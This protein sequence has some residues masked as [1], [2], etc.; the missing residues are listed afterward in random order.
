MQEYLPS[1]LIDRSSFLITYSDS[2]LPGSSC[3]GE[4]TITASSCDNH[5][6]RHFLQIP[7]LMCPPSTDVIVT[8]LARNPLGSGSQLR[9]IIPG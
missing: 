5:L 3:G 7:S 6:C 8:V 1:R 4:A 2:V 9:R